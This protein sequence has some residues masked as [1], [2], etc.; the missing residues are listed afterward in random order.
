MLFMP[1]KGNIS[2]Q[3]L[4]NKNETLTSNANKKEEHEK[5]KGR[6]YQITLKDVLEE[7]V[8]M[9]VYCLQLPLQTYDD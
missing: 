5:I 3:C 6:A 4:L 8:V 7:N 1:R 9:T 2:T